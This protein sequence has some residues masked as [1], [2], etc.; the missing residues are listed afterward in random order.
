MKRSNLYLIGTVHLD[1][2]ARE[3]LYNIIESIIPKIITTEISTFSVRYRTSHQEKWLQHLWNL[4]DSL[5]K[6]R[7]IHSRLKLLEYQLSMPFEWKTTQ[8]YSKVNNISC[9]AIDSGDLARKEL[10]LWE[11]NILSRRNLLRVTNEP[12]FDL[13]TY[14]EDCY[15]QAETILNTA[16]KIPKSIH[17]LLWLSDSY[18][19]KR[20]EILADRIRKIY[21]KYL[22]K[23][24]SNPQTKIPLVHVCG[25]MH[26]VTRSPWKTLADLLSDLNP[27]R[28]ALMR[29]SNGNK[30]L[31]I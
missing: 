17:P 21:R 3:I 4:I 20:E 27:T 25:W 29:T 14:F 24:G 15:L 19:E 11:R 7:K 1:V 13:D 23:F 22:Q 10:P 5:P 31:I 16:D 30:Y 2:G 12:D 9:V 8:R 18:W 28:I 26:L 6:E